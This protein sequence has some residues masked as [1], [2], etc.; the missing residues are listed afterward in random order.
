M[1]YIAPG[2]SFDLGVSN[3]VTLTLSAPTTGTYRGIL[4]YQ[5]RSNSTAASLSKNGNAGALTLSGAMYFP[6]ADLTMK[7]N[8]GV[9]NDC[10]II[11]V[12]TVSLNNNTDLSNTCSGFGGSPILTISMAE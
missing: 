11:V 7:N 12:K 9:T 8:N 5:D 3:F 10:A 1:F 4:F 6:A 2:G